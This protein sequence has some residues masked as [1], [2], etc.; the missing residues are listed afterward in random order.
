MKRAISRLSILLLLAAAGSANAQ[1]LIC[2][3]A[4]GVTAQ[5][6]AVKYGINLIDFTPGA[7]FAIFEG[8]SD[9]VSNELQND[10]GVVWLEDDEAVGSPE[11]QSKGKPTKGGGLPAV[12]TRSGLQKINKNILRQ[13]G[14]SA[15]IAASTGRTVHVAILDTGLGPKQTALWAK[16]DASMNTVEPGS[17]AYD[18]PH[19]T[20]SNGNG[21][22]DEAVGHGTMIAGIIDQ[23][24]PNVRLNVARITDSDGIATGWS[25]IK[26]LAFAVSSKSE[27]ANVSLGSLTNVPALSDV[28][29]WCLANN[30]LIVAPIGNN[31][32]QVICY[33]AKIEGAL[34]VG[35]VDAINQKA[36]F[37]NWNSNCAVS[38]PSVGFASQFWDG[39]LA[40][41]SGTSFAAPVV[42]ATI[43]EALR[44]SKASDPQSMIQATKSTGNQLIHMNPAYKNRMGVL[45][46]FT[47]LV[48]YFNK[49]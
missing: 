44:H 42:A 48:N 7:P 38:A 1:N 13:I 35:G 45:V 41:W 6:L 39:S 28:M 8:S 25:V 15:N 24:A 36:S 4:P 33:P 46:N 11:D 37:S 5:S 30:L 32:L 14:W 49:P 23:I 29:E 16:V 21:I 3:L 2:R 31:D 26:G 9:A 12:G 43:A 18:I 20:D 40:I 10:P 19:G 27:I 47:R 22:P 34:C 17:P